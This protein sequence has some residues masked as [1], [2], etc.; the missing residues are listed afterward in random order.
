MKWLVDL[1]TTTFLARGS[2]PRLV[3]SS[4]PSA[5]VRLVISTTSTPPMRIAAQSPSGTLVGPKL[6]Q[7]SAARPITVDAW[8]RWAG[9]TPDRSCRRSAAGRWRRARHR[10]TAAR[11]RGPRSD[12]APHRSAL[13]A[14]SSRRMLVLSEGAPPPALSEGSAITTGAALKASAAATPPL[15]S[16]NSGMVLPRIDTSSSPSLVASASAL[17]LSPSATTSTRPDSSGTS[18]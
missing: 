2:M 9:R 8:H 10:S 12:P 18:A 11:R 7:Q 15:V 3:K 14:I 17:A 1:T 13:R 4:S 5:C 6:C 16:R